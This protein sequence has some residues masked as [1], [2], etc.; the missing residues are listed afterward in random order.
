MTASIAAMHACSFRLSTH[1][2]GFTI[3]LLSVKMASS[4]PMSAARAQI[5]ALQAEQQEAMD[6]AVAA[7]VADEEATAEAEAEATLLAEENDAQ[8]AALEEMLPPA[9][10]FTADWSEDENAFDLEDQ[11]LGDGTGEPAAGDGGGQAAA[12]VDRRARDLNRGHEQVNDFQGI[13]WGNGPADLE[14]EEDDEF[15]EPEA[16]A[17]GEAPE[18]ILGPNS[19]EGEGDGFDA[20]RSRRIRLPGPVSRKG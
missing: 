6:A 3:Q 11:M 5:A 13:D 15:Y 14:V 9:G 19:S 16:G 10:D 17:D 7:A 18:E 8:A 4:P 20:G 1:S 12:N 2:L